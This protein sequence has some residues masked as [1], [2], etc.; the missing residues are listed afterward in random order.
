MRPS[1]SSSGAW[2]LFDT[3]PW[4]KPAETPDAG[5]CN[6]R[7]FSTVPSVVRMSSVTLWRARISRYFWA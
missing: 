3:P 2:L 7:R 5:S 1:D 4:T 6:S